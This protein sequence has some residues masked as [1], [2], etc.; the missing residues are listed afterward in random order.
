MI[1]AAEDPDDLTPRQKRDLDS[2]DRIGPRGERPRRDLD[3][4]RFSQTPGDNRDRRCRC[5]I[6][7][8]MLTYRCARFGRDGE[9][10]GI[11]DANLKH[12]DGGLVRW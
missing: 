6:T 12:S 5:E 10:E 9:H 4:C 8:G 7:L 11:H 3:T 1:D 2:F